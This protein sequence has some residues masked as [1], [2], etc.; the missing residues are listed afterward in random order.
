MY[1]KYKVI[2][3]SGRYYIT[4]NA[5]L[6]ANQ[7]KDLFLEIH[8]TGTP[9]ACALSYYGGY[10]F[11]VP[12]DLHDKLIDIEDGFECKTNLDIQVDES[13]N[14]LMVYDGRMD[15]IETVPDC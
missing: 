14:L 6:H 1:N 8:H 5:R 4:R 11:F 7:K 12:E 9:Y 2:L 10:I 13:G 3:P 15:V